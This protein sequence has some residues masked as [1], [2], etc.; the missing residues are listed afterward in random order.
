MINER[1]AFLFII[2]IFLV[3][4]LPNLNY[5]GISI[6]EAAD[7]IVSS[8]I[9]KDSAIYYNKELMITNCY[10]VLFNRILP[11]MSG[12]YLGSVLAYLVYPFARIFGL[13]IISLR[14]TP[15][16][17]SILTILFIYL[18]CKIWFGKR[19]AFFASLLAATNLL[20]VQYSRVGLYRE[21][22][23]I[24]FFFWATLF[25]FAKYF[26]KKAP[27]FLY[28]GLFLFGLGLS[29][30]ITFFWYVCGM[31]MGYIILKKRLN[32]LISLKIRQRVIGLFT[33]CL[34][35]IFI[36]FYN[37]KE[38]GVTVKMLTRSLLE[39]PFV[40]ENMSISN[41]SYFTNLKIRI[42]QLLMFLKENIAV[43]SDWGVI[44]MCPIERASFII[45]SVAAI[46]FISVL[47]FALFSLNSS[48]K[49]R[50]LFFYIIYV[51]VMLLTPF[52]VS[53]FDPGHLLVLF[54]FPQ[55]T[56]ALF[57]DYIWQWNKYKKAILTMAC[58]IFLIPVLLFNIW[59]NVYFNTEMKKNGGYRRWSTAVYELANYLDKKNIQPV[60]FGWGMAENIVFLS[61]ERIVPVVYTE[62][63]FI[64]ERFA[65]ER[66]SLSL[67]RKP[68]FY[69]TMISEENQLLRDLFMK[70]AE[71][72][73]ENKTSE[74]IFFN[75]AGD[76]VYWLYKIY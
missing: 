36:I 63:N 51:T 68:I 30:K 27:H 13:N 73:R 25:F 3:L 58:S 7:G 31:L 6:D 59:V 54:P 56:M 53:S 29:A 72:N 24:I 9:L 45:V 49:Y 1:T 67:K 12:H 32:L 34:G 70:L 76:P 41:L 5:P 42:S 71:E 2:A 75:L 50:I 35:A 21:E 44:Q 38:P 11:V 52:T 22:I 20:F 40:K 69:L 62:A 48:R 17:F 46:S 55:I 60:M 57:L 26:E 37:I 64:L 16:F 33:F 14:I 10:V 61:H 4:T 65:K 19:V 15:I 47:I 8:Y 18:L 28:I 39:Y 66:K 74:R 23:F 43:R